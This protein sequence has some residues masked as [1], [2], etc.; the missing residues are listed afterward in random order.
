MGALIKG[1]R[2]IYK[3]HGHYQ[4]CA[5][6]AKTG[7]AIGNPLKA[8]YDIDSLR[9]SHRIHLSRY[10]SI[11]LRSRPNTAEHVCAHATKLWIGIKYKER[12][13]IQVDPRGIELQA[14]LFL[15]LSL[16]SSL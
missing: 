9:R 15:G 12:Q 16:G 11:T 8:N 3:E 14:I 10:C 4:N 1:P 7:E 13:A 6:D 5:V 2:H